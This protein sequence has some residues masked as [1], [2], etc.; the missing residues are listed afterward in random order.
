LYLYWAI[1]FILVE[2]LS[3]CSFF[4]SVPQREDDSHVLHSRSHYADLRFFFIPDLLWVFKAPSCYFRWGRYGSQ[5]P[6]HFLVCVCARTSVVHLSHG[7]LHRIHEPSR[8]V[9]KGPNYRLAKDARSE[10]PS[11]LGETQQS[12]RGGNSAHSRKYKKIQSCRCSCSPQS[13]QNLS[14]GS[15]VSWRRW[16]CSRRRRTSSPCPRRWTSCWSETPSRWS[17]SPR[18]RACSS[19][20]WSTRSPARQGLALILKW[21][22]LTSFCYATATMFVVF[23]ASSVIRSRCT[24]ATVTLMSSTRFCC[25]GL[26]TGWCRRCRPKECWREVRPSAFTALFLSSFCGFLSFWTH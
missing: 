12:S 15:R 17:S 26:P 6:R 4:Q 13:Y 22:H 18:R 5:L 14:S 7:T 1:Y 21:F 10:T 25:R 23:V 3:L 2:K 24:G 20:T 19:N 9:P 11:N 8:N 16:G